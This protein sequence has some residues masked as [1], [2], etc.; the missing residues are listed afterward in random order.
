MRERVAEAGGTLQVDSQPGAGTRITAHLPLGKPL[1]RRT[2]VAA[3][4]S[5][6][7]PWREEPLAARGL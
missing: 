5:D 1:G 7:A 2:V 3:S 4:L 6:D